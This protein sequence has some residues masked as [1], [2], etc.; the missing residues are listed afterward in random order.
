[1]HVNVIVEYIG[2]VENCV[3]LEN[4]QFETA[5]DPS[6]LVQAG[7]GISSQFAI[8]KCWTDVALPCSPHSLYYSSL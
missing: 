8:C 7:E 3:C 4:I 1:M 2:P 6:I 5:S